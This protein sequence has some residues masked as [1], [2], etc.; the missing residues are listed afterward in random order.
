MAGNGNIL[1]FDL[2]G[3]IDNQS[4]THEKLDSVFNAIYEN[5]LKGGLLYVVTARRLCDF[6]DQFQVLKYNI[7]QKLIDIILHV[8]NNASHRWLYYNDDLDHPQIEALKLLSKNQKIKHF[9]N[10]CEK[11]DR[12]IINMS[13]G[14]QKM[15][16]IEEILNL[17][18]KKQ[19]LVDS[20][21]SNKKRV[22]FFDDSNDNFLAYVY[23][24]TYINPS[25]KRV[26]FVGGFDRAVFMDY[27]PSCINV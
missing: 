18:P 14:I 2:D 5:F 27:S 11:M 10:H 15:I 17:A 12:H 24:T 4:L 9:E 21:S 3:T 13:M 26:S 6:Q 20:V 16:Q 22:Y 25:M 23:Y 7:P 8:N 1:I 19:I